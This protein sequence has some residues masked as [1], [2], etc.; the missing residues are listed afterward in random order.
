MIGASGKGWTD[1]FTD[2]EV[3]NEPCSSVYEKE[4]LPLKLTFGW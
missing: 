1:I 4:S 2:A 3:L